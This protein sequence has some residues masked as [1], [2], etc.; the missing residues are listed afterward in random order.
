MVWAMARQ[1]YR[2]AVIFL[3]HEKVRAARDSI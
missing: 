2:Q 3:A 1:P